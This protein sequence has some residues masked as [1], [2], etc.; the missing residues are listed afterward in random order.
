MAKQ[1]FVYINGVISP[2]PSDGFFS[3]DPTCSE[4]DVRNQLAALDTD[5]DEVVVSINSPGGSVDEGFAIYN[6]LKSFGKSITTKATG[7]CASIATIIL[8]AGKKRL[9]FSN[10]SPLIHYP[11]VR[12]DGSAMT[13]DDLQ[14]M[15]DELKIQNDRILNEYVAVTG[16]DR[17][18]LEAKMKPDVSLTA[19]EALDLGF[20]TEI[21]QPTVAVYRNKAMAKKETAAFKAAKAFASL[22][23]VEIVAEGAEN[24]VEMTTTDGKIITFD[25]D[26]SVGATATIDGQPAPDNSYELEDGTV[27]VCVGGK[28]DSITTPAT[29]E[30]KDLEAANAKIAELTAQLADKETAINTLTEQVQNLEKQ[31]TDVAAQVNKLTDGL[32]AL[33]VKVDLPTGQVVFNKDHKDAPK[34]AEQIR[35]EVKAAAERT[36]KK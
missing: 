10:S 22:L 6:T 14:S 26:M 32:R 18:V 28:V 36:K 9:G 15:A 12:P 19:Q 30:N 33:N 5:I 8:L 24:M 4:V 7:T 3:T 17:A 25:P 21:I 11:Y 16:A 27:V 13:A 23:G 35:A 31:N 1:G 34:T 29:D 2:V 20:F